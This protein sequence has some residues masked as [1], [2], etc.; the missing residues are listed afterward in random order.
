MLDVRTAPASSGVWKKRYF[1]LLRK[2]VE[3]EQP[4]FMALLRLKNTHRPVSLYRYRSFDEKGYSL[5]NLRDDAV[6]LSPPADFNDP[7]DSNFQFSAGDNLLRFFEKDIPALLHAVGW[8]LSCPEAALKYALAGPNPFDA[9]FQLAVGK[10]GSPRPGDGASFKAELQRALAERS[11]SVLDKLTAQVRDRLRI[12]CFSE[13]LD[14]VLM[15]SHYAR[16]HTGFCIEYSGSELFKSLVVLRSLHPVCYRSDFYDATGQLDT[17]M[18]PNFAFHVI[19]ACAKSPEW[20]YEKEWRLIRPSDVMEDPPMFHLPTPSRIILGAKT[21][22][23]N[24]KVISEIAAAKGIV[25]SAARLSRDQASVD[26]KG[27]SS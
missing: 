10:E 15:W 6:W 25:V 19:A 22:A 16:A 12:C 24:R 4:N 1:T 17:I 18:D 2:G 5:A 13:V 20:A 8:K 27:A 23:E 7:F 9:L 11:I 14:S 21:S 26:V 3:N